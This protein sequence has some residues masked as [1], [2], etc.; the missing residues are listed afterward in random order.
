MKTTENIMQHLYKFS[1]DFLEHDGTLIDTEQLTIEIGDH[2]YPKVS[3]NK[4]HVHVFERF[5]TKEARLSI[6]N[7][8]AEDWADEHLYT[9]DAHSFRI[10][11]LDS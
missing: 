4:L 6:A 10:V 3:R 5:M 8:W 11:L 9:H 1:I 2:P 7:K